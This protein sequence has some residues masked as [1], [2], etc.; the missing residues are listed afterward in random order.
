M[1]KKILIANRGEIAVRIIRSCRELNIL[2]VAVYSD[3]DRHSLHVRYADEAYH[4]GPSK[5]SESYLKSDKILEIAQQCGADAIHPGYGFLAERADFSQACLDR[6]ISFIGP[7]PSSIA[8]MGDKQVARDTVTKAG[9]PVVPG[10]EGQGDLSDEALLEIAP[11]IGFPL[12]I[13]PSA[14]GGGKGMREVLN[15]KE[16]PGLLTAS[17]REAES[18]FGDGNIYLEK[19]IQGARHIEIQILADQHGS[20][21]HL[22]EREC[23]IQRRHQKLLEEAPSPFIGDDQNLRDKMGEVAVQAA[24]A[25]DYI[26]AGTIE[27]LVDKDKNYYFLE[28]NTRLQV[29]HPVTEAVTG[30]DIVK[31]QIRIA[32][33]QPLNLKQEDITMKGWAMEC[34]IN[35]EDPFRGFLPS[36][37]LIT[38]SIIPAGPGIRIDTGVYSGYE[39]SSYYDALI[40]KL[41]VHEESRKETITRMK[42]ALD[43]Y[44]VIGI[45]TNIPFHQALLENQDFLTGKFNT[46]FIQDSN[47]P[48]S[49]KQ[50]DQSL[51]EIA[52]L[53]AVLATHKR[54]QRSAISI[55]RG[56]RDTSNWK[57][58]GRWE[59]TKD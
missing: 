48:I 39:I 10:T 20:V 25:V 12:L 40:S 42:R 43:E 32:A 26:N 4:L 19:L 58:V 17:R 46:Q 52:A 56:K 50:M 7:K 30:I 33:G 35:A 54:T 59:R 13:K 9:V 29:E 47:L 18:S 27:F 57:L 41:I 24:R 31:E 16:M 51:P 8:A 21:I 37:G 34:R 22:G 36:T 2:T 11:E 15:I 14:G 53:T 55:Q 38:Q 23:S 28:M 44:R 49:G 1:F 6:G 3:A 5:A 45:R